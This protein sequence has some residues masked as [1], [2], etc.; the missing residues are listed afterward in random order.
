MA[1]NLS[2]WWLRLG[3]GIDRVRV[4]RLV[5]E[6]DTFGLRSTDSSTGLHRKAPRILPSRACT[7][8]ATTRCHLHPDAHRE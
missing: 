5:V 7:F 6:L 8:A 4:V 2:V 1:S 3:I